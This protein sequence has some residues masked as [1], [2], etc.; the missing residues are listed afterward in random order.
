[1]GVVK[2]NWPVKLLALAVAI[3]LS[4]Y[5]RRQQDRATKRMFLPVI[6]PAPAGQR[7]VEPSAGTTV[8]V[9]LEGP[10][11]LISSVNQEEISLTIDPSGVKPGRAVKVPVSIEIP[12]RLRTRGVEAAWQPQTI[13][14]K[15]ISDA[16]RQLGVEVEPTEMPEGW[17]LKGPP[18]TIPAQ[19]AIS[20]AQ[21][22]VDS[23]HRLTVA[24]PLE[25]KEWVR[26]LA[27][28]RAED[29]A[30]TDITDLVKPIPAQVQISASLERVVL[31]K[32]VPVQPVFR[33]PAGMR[34]TAEVVP[35]TVRVIGPERRLTTVYVVETAPFEVP[36]GK[37][38]FTKSI[39]LITPGTGIT[40]R[41]DQ[42][43]VI[44]T[45][46]PLTAARPVR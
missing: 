18:E 23:V 22:D 44:I 38:P 12:E 27:S 16:R 17:G 29:A 9:D 33:A 7:V 30:G 8:R 39:A 13:P 35:P 37:S 26:E 32:D 43:K 45:A 3:V 40:M 34:V 14:I 41:P 42:V 6:I 46:Q 20:G 10:A 28:V 4:F 15:L 5:V 31:Q 19:V 24:L 36:A 2:H 21:Q 1:M 11:E 25:P